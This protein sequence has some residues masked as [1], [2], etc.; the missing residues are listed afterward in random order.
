VISVGGDVAI[1][2]RVSGDVISW[3]G[4]VVVSE[5]GAI[6][7]DLVVFGGKIS[8]ADGRVS[9]RVL[10][11]GSLLA[12]YL[13][14][15]KRLAA[16]GAVGSYSTWFGL[17]LFVLGLW[18]AAATLILRF[19]GPA[20]ARAALTVQ[21][22]PGLSAAGGVLTLIL[23]LLAGVTALSALPQRAAVPV[24]LILLIFAAA[25]K[26]FG[27]TALF[28]YVGQTVSRNVSAAGRP[29][30]LCLGF[31]LAGVVSLVPTAGPILWSA[32]SVLAVGVSALTRF[33]SPRFRISLA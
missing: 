22:S 31:A 24:A 30:A 10:T 23:F 12:I 9:G 32:L 29:A 26:I 8:G 33:G 18:L 4:S 20:S 25:M 27:M 17:R 16:T 1:R 15:E 5:T 14:E 3:G 7:G 13:A 21:E 2:A 19:F 6:D 28:L 11:P